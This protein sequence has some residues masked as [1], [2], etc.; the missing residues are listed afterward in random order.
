ML[1][2][3]D[4]KSG[5]YYAD[6]DTYTSKQQKVPVHVKCYHKEIM[7]PGRLLFIYLGLYINDISAITCGFILSQS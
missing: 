5:R 4:T 3:Y 2:V 1:V 6:L 7:S